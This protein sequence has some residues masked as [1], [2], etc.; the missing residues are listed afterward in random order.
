MK[1]IAQ[2]FYVNQPGS[3]IPGVYVTK[4]DLYFKKVSNI[5]G[6]ELQIRTTTNGVPTVER[7]PFA[8]KFL[9][10]TDVNP[11]RAS[12]NAS[13]ATTFEFD[14]PVFLQTGVSYA[15]VLIPV[16]G[17]PDYQIWTA[18]I[19]QVDA[20]N[21]TPI[22]TNNETG[23][24]FLSSNDKS[25]IPIITEDMK[26]TIYTAN[27]TSL[28]GEA[29]FRSPNEDYL[30]I[31]DIVGSFLLG[32]P[33]YASSNRYD[34]ARLNVTGVNGVFLIGDFVY[35][36]NGTA[37][38]ATGYVYFANS[39][40]I[41]LQNTSAAFVANTLFNAN[42]VSNAAVTSVSQNASITLNSNTFTVPDNNI[43]SVN[44][45]IYVA[46]SNFSKTQLLRVKSV[47]GDGITLDVSN[48]VL[49]G[50]NVSIF[51]DT[52]CIYGK[53]LNNG[54][55]VGGLGA[56]QTFPDLTRIIIDNVS[57]TS[58]NNFNG[59]IGKRL[60][61]LFSYASANVYNVVDMPYNQISPQITHV[62]P[63]NTSISWSFKGFRNNQNYS[64]DSSY[65]S[66]DEGISNE[67]IDF[68]RVLM[69]RSNEVSKLP[70]GRTGD[71]S[72]K[73]KAS[74]G[75]SNNRVSPVIDVL[76]KFSHFT[77][78]VCVPKNYLKGFYIKIANSTGIFANGSLVSQ[79]NSNAIVRFANSSYVLITDATN[80][81]N[82][83]NTRLVLN[84]N[85]SVNAVITAAEYYN[86]SLD[87]GLF[88]SSR[89]I[90]KNIVLAA[91]QSSEDI[92]AF[93]GA[94]RPYTT[95]L[96]V[97][98]KIINSQDAD[99][100]N[101]KHWSSLIERTNTS[102]L[103]SQ[104]NR[105]DLVELSYGF[106]Q[107]INISP[108]NN[109]CNTTSNVVSIGSPYSS[110]DISVGNYIY[111]SD[112]VTK[113]FNVRRVVNVPN[114]TAV[115]VE[116]AFSFA[117]SNVAFGHIPGLQSASGAFLNDQNNNIVRYVTPQDLVFDTYSQFSIKIVPVS[118]TTAI[119]P[120][121][122]DMR[123]LAIQA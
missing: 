25:W 120:R 38:T 74:M 35:Q 64:E 46:T 65:I 84:S 115:V 81:F 70:V 116:S 108:N 76:S 122:A 24:L 52:N 80:K 7:L 61:G 49:N 77:Y 16:G 121:V 20:L 33:L 63:A 59:A 10:P 62:A 3:N 9:F 54:T 103:S 110:V 72:V 79:N 105:D 43:F 2:T 117:S 56:S 37:N 1:P 69:A 29:I 104:V 99:R 31:K 95:N 90:S 18:E 85:N 55:L 86:E 92:L 32:E 66:V 12:D 34:N 60:I 5:Q 28:S 45:M 94:Y 26:F 123:V 50:T 106:P 88:N 21:N 89:Y 4:V 40:V 15:L 83:N 73:I 96:L 42:S 113:Q 91:G 51:T 68:E 119:V 23:D 13:V 109:S 14:T 98:A 82:A 30:E 27:F 71:R 44:D 8:S 107:S 111:V 118:A 11:P 47:N 22:Y 67:M 39:T 100:Y 97:Y 58:G 75:S 93:L 41:R 19:G 6:I 87:N 57:S 114:T 48:A 53:V 36:S 101:D 112:G 102:L 17:N 78:N